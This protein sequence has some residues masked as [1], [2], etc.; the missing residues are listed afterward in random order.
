MA[1]KILHRSQMRPE[2]QRT[3][4]EHSSPT[5][6]IVQRPSVTQ[7]KGGTGTPG[8]V[9]KRDRERRVGGSLVLSFVIQCHHQPSTFAGARRSCEV[10]WFHFKRRK[11]GTMGTSVGFIKIFFLTF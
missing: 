9:L 5:R 11:T 10:G 3:D 6:Y 7:R 2:A 1:E 8:D 4:W